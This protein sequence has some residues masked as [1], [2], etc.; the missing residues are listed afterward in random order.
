V[1]P[2]GAYTAELWVDDLTT[3]YRTF[4]ERTI[5]RD[6]L[7]PKFEFL[8]AGNYLTGS[9]G[10][11]SVTGSRSVSDRIL[12]VMLD[13]NVPS[14]LPTP[15]AVWE[16]DSI[17]IEDYQVHPYSRRIL[18]ELAEFKTHGEAASKEILSD[19]ANVGPQWRV[20][21]PASVL[22]VTLQTIETLSHQP[23]NPVL[24]AMEWPRRLHW[25]LL[26]TGYKQQLDDKAT[27]Q[28]RAVHAIN[29]VRFLA[30]L[31]L[32]DIEWQLLA[33]P[34]THKDYDMY[35]PMPQ[36]KM[37]KQRRELLLVCAREFGL[38]VLKD[39]QGF[40][41]AA[42]GPLV[43]V[44][45][46]YAFTCCPKGPHPQWSATN[47]GPNTEISGMTF[48]D[49]K[50]S[51]NAAFILPIVKKHSKELDK[52][53]EMCAKHGM[54]SYARLLS[55]LPFDTLGADG[56]TTIHYLIRLLSI[57]G[58]CVT[59]EGPSALRQ[60]EPAHSLEEVKAARFPALEHV[61]RITR[62]ILWAT[63]S[64]PEQGP[65]SGETYDARILKFLTQRS[66]A[67]SDVKQIGIYLSDKGDAALKTSQR[68]VSVRMGSKLL[69][70][71]MDP[72]AACVMGPYL[73]S[74]DWMT[75][76]W[77][78]IEIGVDDPMLQTYS[79]L[80][81]KSAFRSV[82]AR[83]LRLVCML[84]CATHMTAA[85]LL[86]PMY[87]VLKRDPP[88]E[89]RE[90]PLL[91]QNVFH[92][93]K[94]DRVLGEM[95][96]SLWATSNKFEEHRVLSAS[97]DFDSFDMTVTYREKTEYAN[98]M[99]AALEALGSADVEYD[100]NY[101][102]R[103]DGG[104]LTPR[105]IV[106]Q[107]F[108]S[109]LQGAQ[110]LV[111]CNGRWLL[112]QHR[113]NQ[114]GRFDTTLLNGIINLSNVMC[115]LQNLPHGWVAI[116]LCIQGDDVI[117]Q[118]R[119]PPEVDVSECY[120]T[121][122]AASLTAS[123]DNCKLTSAVKTAA[124]PK[125]AS[126]TR[127][128]IYYG[129]EFHNS[130]S[131]H[132]TAEHSRDA[133]PVE[134]LQSIRQLILMM[135]ARG[136]DRR[137]MNVY[138][139][140]TTWLQLNWRVYGTQGQDVGKKGATDVTRRVYAPPFALL[141][142]LSLGGIGWTPGMVTPN[143]WTGWY[144]LLRDVVR[145]QSVL[146]MIE[147]C[148]GIL[149]S[150]KGL[151]SQLAEIGATDPSRLYSMRDGK[152]VQDPGALSKGRAALEALTAN[153]ARHRAVEA[154]R[155]L[156]SM[157]IRFPSQLTVMERATRLVERGL[158]G[159]PAILKFATRNT[160]SLAARTAER[161][162]RK[163]KFVR[164]SGMRTLQHVVFVHNGL[165]PLWGPYAGDLEVASDTTHWC[166]PFALWTPLTLFLHANFPLS[167]S[168][169][170]TRPTLENLFAPARRAGVSSDISPETLFAVLSHPSFARDEKAM[171]LGLV[172]CGA[173]TQAATTAAKLIIRRLPEVMQEL[174]VEG[175]SM[176]TVVTSRLD[177]SQKTAEAFVSYAPSAQRILAGKPSA[178]IV[179]TAALAANLEF[180]AL[181]GR[182]L[183]FR[184]T[185]SRRDVA[186][187]IME[188]YGPFATALELVTLR[189]EMD[190]RGENWD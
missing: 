9:G 64:L 11:I 51:G 24:T 190:A 74:D 162:M 72:T 55:Q 137:Y 104:K 77:E 101:L 81:N 98:G 73:S 100:S 99:I 183:N 83:A 15:E 87:E 115:I 155:T 132:R 120:E 38:Q 114:S 27:V 189:M 144:I 44:P 160:A 154:V 134:V 66:A 175:L 89:R 60:L 172:A 45:V 97:L 16:M 47:V 147:H 178:K 165:R 112:V 152:F 2:N 39:P 48:S 103:A 170:K 52:G 130:E 90:D 158:A 14:D 42:K 138:F 176:S 181:T 111:R 139:M 32:I 61:R 71:M 157:H 20:G 37:S 1:L 68:I 84:P 117:L 124:S 86:D 159:A 58:Y 116:G 102:R 153:D 92:F 163:G 43:N 79:E 118:V 8:K 106:Q 23:G 10:L 67:S 21:R 177:L 156:S 41:L 88:E 75:A 96:T 54:P 3:K 141:T 82:T 29:G 19:L 179:A 122:L 166:T 57:G 145:G 6:N 22:A 33:E 135:V 25:W 173:T 18:D 125:F 46:L 59:R 171:M 182:A 56:F 50:L 123:K 151:P 121:F 36:A 186:G 119:L 140:Y 12:P 126:Y 188:Y 128:R 146:Q 142:P 187:M 184:V 94:N 80:A 169:K 70:W 65:M 110:Y 34:A 53:V 40:T 13:Y 30:F 28:D 143:G 164:L 108:Q 63:R 180:A 76:E 4:L 113:G 26:A 69:L 133:G 49:A 31:N 7:N 91:P 185:S 35:G 109:R 161:L 174:D 62:D 148:G 131:Q 5:R 105:W 127:R 78:P 93:S 129:L 95:A 85:A 150:L 149:K 107:V 167:F 136:W 168:F 17:D